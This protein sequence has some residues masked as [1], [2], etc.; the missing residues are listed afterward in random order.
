M[1]NTKRR[2]AKHVF[3]FFAGESL[4]K[5]IASVQSGGGRGEKLIP[6]DTLNSGP[7]MARSEFA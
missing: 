5:V 2:Q 7:H 6:P 1:R 3:G 4:T